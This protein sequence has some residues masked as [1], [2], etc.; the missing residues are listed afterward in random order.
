MNRIDILSSETS[1]K[2]AAGEVIERPLSVVKELVENSIDAGSKNITVL[3]QE[4]GLK[5]INITD[6]GSGI[7]PD[8]IEKSILPHATSKISTIDDIFKIN[9]LGFRGEALAS[10]AAISKMNITS[11]IKSMDFGRELRVEGGFVK[12]IKDAAA[13]PGTSIVVNDLFF[14]VPARLKFLKSTSKESSSITDIV[15]R[16]ALSHSDICFILKNNDKQ[17]IH[18]FGNNNLQDVI[19]IIYGKSTGDNVTYFENHMDTAT[20]YGY[21]GNADVSRGSRNHQTIFVNKRYIRSKLVTAAVENAF[22]SFLTIN[23][24]PFFVLFLDIYPELVDVNVHP[25]KSEIKFKNDREI[26]KLVFDSIHKAIRESLH[27]DFN[28][29]IDT[30]SD[31]VNSSS[32]N[33]SV[34]GKQIHKN[35]SIFDND[36]TDSKPIKVDIPIDLRSSD[37]EQHIDNNEPSVQS[38][39]TPPAYINENAEPYIKPS[40]KPIDTDNNNKYTINNRLKSDYT[41]PNKNNLKLKLLKYIGIFNNTYIL[42]ELNEELFIIDQHAAHERVMF[43]RYREQ[44][45]QSHVSVQTLLTPI[46][47]ELTPEEYSIY[48]DN[49]DIFKNSGF[50]IDIF[51][52]NTIKIQA[53][54]YILGKLDGRNFFIQVIDSIKNDKSI[55]TLDLKYNSIA[56]LACR[57]AVKAHQKLSEVEVKTLLQ[58]LAECENPYNCPH[59]RPTIISMS[60]YEIEKKFKRVQ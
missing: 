3:I 4:G 23:K 14:N 27:D 55:D 41:T 44:I 43:E 24:F 42:S 6:D 5:T 60:L 59:G 45:K 39:P 58:Q 10:I 36:I 51:G 50:D 22:K 9:T 12:S 7:H 57:S 15:S 37:Y 54:P 17:V 8:D 1:N 18:T 40:A 56:R 47:L 25:T 19:R 52:D 33:E 28:I 29:P 49:I 38:K 30:H 48:I 34:E 13:N 35:M 32:D 21:I 20:V 16:L 46:V 31:I 26:F 11:R 53:V 2:I